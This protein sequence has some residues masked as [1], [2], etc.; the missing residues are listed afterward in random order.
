MALTLSFQH[1]LFVECRD[2]GLVNLSVQ[3]FPIAGTTDI[4][5]A[6]GACGFSHIEPAN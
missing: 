4:N 3:A 2:C 1:L 6:C 5:W